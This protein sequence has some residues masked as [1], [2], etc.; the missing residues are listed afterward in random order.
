MLSKCQK[1][2][3]QLSSLLLRQ[4]GG[5]PCHV[6]MVTTMISTLIPCMLSVNG[7][8]KLLVNSEMVERYLLKKNT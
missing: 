3:I 8:L 7:Q 5:T 2:V 1:D 4:G 6:D